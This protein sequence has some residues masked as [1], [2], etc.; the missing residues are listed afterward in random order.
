MMERATVRCRDVNLSLSLL[1]FDFCLVLKGACY[2]LWLNNL[3]PM[4]QQF[5]KTR[6]AIKLQFHTSLEDRH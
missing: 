6:A 4:L 1:C 2:I 3:V 5:P